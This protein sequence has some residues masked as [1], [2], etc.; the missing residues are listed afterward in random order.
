MLVLLFLSAKYGGNT[1]SLKNIALNVVLLLVVICLSFNITHLVAHT[2]KGVAVVSQNKELT[3][4]RDRQVIIFIP[5]SPQE[6]EKIGTNNNIIELT[7]SRSEEGAFGFD[8]VQNC[9]LMPS[10][11]LRLQRNICSNHRVLFSDRDLAWMNTS[12]IAIVV[13]VHYATV[14]RKFISEVG[15]K[16]PEI[17]DDSNAFLKC[18]YVKFAENT[19]D[20]MFYLCS[21]RTVVVDNILP[22]IKSEIV[23][24]RLSENEVILNIYDVLLWEVFRSFP[25]DKFTTNEEKKLWLDG[26]DGRI[27]MFLLRNFSLPSIT[28]S[29]DVYLPNP[30]TTRTL[31]SKLDWVLMNMAGCA[32][33]E[34]EEIL[35]S[36][37]GRIKN[38]LC[39]L[40][41]RLYSYNFLYQVQGYC[42]DYHST[43]YDLMCKD[44]R[45]RS[46][47][48][49]FA[50]ASC[51]DSS[52]AAMTNNFIHGLLRSVNCCDL[53][54]E[55][56]YVLENGCFDKVIDS[57]MA[58]YDTLGLR[59]ILKML[60][61]D[62]EKRYTFRD[63]V[64]CAREHLVKR[65]V[66]N[67]LSLVPRR[68]L[69]TEVG[70]VESVVLVSKKNCAKEGASAIMLND[71]VEQCS[72]SYVPW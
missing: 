13:N 64:N 51:R 72:Y 43:L 34:S 49:I 7:G 31:N 46:Y 56:Q 21:T 40:D 38:V 14:T 20:L 55:V 61:M 44:L 52:D 70:K 26:N 41:C 32:V 36:V 18:E 8:I 69:S 67:S 15:V 42:I 19:K 62:G 17:R 58:C 66:V 3:I 10:R 16:Y 71:I 60:S 39:N 5:C 33:I 57:S 12:G 54:G 29:R 37:F 28:G 59:D 1:L 4:K 23:C 45:D 65:Y 27:A 11:R 9:G 30:E 48:C 25:S 6:L 47:Q 63:L 24:D 50:L 68:I 53:I 35:T 2:S 22:E